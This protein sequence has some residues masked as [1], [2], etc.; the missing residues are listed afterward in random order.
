MFVDPCITVQFLQR[1]S[2]QDA[3]VYQ[4]FIIPYFK[5]SSTCFG[6]HTAHHQEP[7]TAQ[8]ASGF[9]MWKVV[10]RAAATN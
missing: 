2:Q 4:N 3:T 7:K 10:G 8:A 9:H 6:R 1:K 5:G